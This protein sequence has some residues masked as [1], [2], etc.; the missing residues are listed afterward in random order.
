MKVAREAV[1]VAA[2]WQGVQHSDTLDARLLLS[3]VLQVR[4]PYVPVFESLNLKLN[5]TEKTF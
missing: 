3:K 2:R 1:R 5:S 4:G